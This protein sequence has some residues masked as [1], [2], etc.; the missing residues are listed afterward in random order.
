MEQAPTNRIRELREDRAW[1]LRDLEQRSGIT[2]TKLHRIET[3]TTAPDYNDLKKIAK[4]FDIRISGLL[5]DEDVELRVDEFGQDILDLLTQIPAPERPDVL[6]AARHV[7]RAVTGIA[8]SRSSAAL[9]GDP[10]LVSK[11]A[12][13]WN[14]LQD[15][16]R[17]YA[18]DLWNIAKLGRSP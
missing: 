13:R 10:E 12:H 3:G 15:S 5:I 9:N 17:P 8:A 11:L 18:L 6:L 7:A 14:T 4:A 2:H 16:D 1:S